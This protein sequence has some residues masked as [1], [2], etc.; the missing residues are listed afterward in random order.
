MAYV[1]ME[2]ETCMN[3]RATTI[4]AMTRSSAEE[5]KAMASGVICLGGAVTSISEG[6][7]DRL[8]SV[9]VIERGG[10]QQN[11]PSCTSSF[12]FRLASLS[13]T[14]TRNSACKRRSVQDGIAPKD[15]SHPNSTESS[16]T[17]HVGHPKSVLLAFESCDRQ[18]MGGRHR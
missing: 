3:T 8:W 1:L 14:E 9:L 16:H 11:W 17:D 5:R 15:S 18:E 13:R 6:R 7:G 2:T 12:W 4:I 10:A